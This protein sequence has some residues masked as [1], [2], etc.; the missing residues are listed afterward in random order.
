MKGSLL[1]S[2]QN[3]QAVWSGPTAAPPVPGPVPGPL[4]PGPV[5]PVPGVKGLP[6][7]PVPG[8]D[9]P[10]VVGL[11]SRGVLGPVGDLPPGVGS[12]VTSPGPRYVPPC[13]STSSVPMAK[14]QANA[15]PVSI[16]C[17][18]TR[19]VSRGWRRTGLADASV[20]VR[21]KERAG[22]S[23][24]TCICREACPH[25]SRKR[26]RVAV[27]ARQGPGRSMRRAWPTSP[28]CYGPGTSAP[29]ALAAS[30]ARGGVEWCLAFS[31]GS[32]ERADAHGSP[33]SGIVLRDLR[34]LPDSREEEPRGGGGRQL[35]RLRRSAGSATSEWL[36]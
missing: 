18:M 27:M 32:P 36:R 20:G 26:R 6:L 21:C 29:P 3:S 12:G 25:R 9:G 17:L 4:P 15:H 16:Q 33:R 1:N 13:A 7:L 34:T 22:G 2:H 5:G 11:P 30:L 14:V 19:R 35:D 23:D 8:P 28:G 24:L 10:G 31:V